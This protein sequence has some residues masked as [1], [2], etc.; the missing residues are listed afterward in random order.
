MISSQPRPS[1][2]WHMLGIVGMPQLSHLCPS[3]YPHYPA[4]CPIITSS[5]TLHCIQPP[6]PRSVGHLSSLLHLQSSRLHW[7]QHS[8]PSQSEPSLHCLLHHRLSLTFQLSWAQ[9]VALLDCTLEG[10]MPSDFSI[11]KASEFESNAFRMSKTSQKYFKDMTEQTV[12]WTNHYF[13]NVQHM[14]LHSV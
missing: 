11:N 13:K 1:L 12:Y 14:L 7:P 6:V 10:W 5:L 3:L 9:L 8:H 2:A 4:S